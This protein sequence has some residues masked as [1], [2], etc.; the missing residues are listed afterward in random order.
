MKIQPNAITY[1]SA[2]VNG[3]HDVF[4]PIIYNKFIYSASRNGK[5]VKIVR[6]QNGQLGVKSSSL[7]PI[8]ISYRYNWASIIGILSSI[9][10]W[11]LGIYLIFN[12]KRNLADA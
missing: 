9:I 8:K 7:G 6:G 12:R 4:L 3:S 11:G 10:C 1:D 2:D 5:K